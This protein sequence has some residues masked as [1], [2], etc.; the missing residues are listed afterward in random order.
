[1]AFRIDLFD[2]LFTE[3]KKLF[4][5]KIKT[6]IEVGD[7]MSEILV[8]YTR[9][10]K[11]ESMHR[12]DIVAVNT[13]GKIIDCIGDAHKKMFWRSAAKPFQALPFVAKGGVEQYGITQEELALLVS[14]HSGES[15]HVDL[16]NHILNKIALDS[17][18]LDCGTS[19]PMSSKAAKLLIENKQKPEAFHNACSGKHAGML[20]LCQMLGISIAGYT[21]PEHEVQKQ[22]HASVAQ[23]AK[24]S[25]SELEIGIDGCGVPV[26]YLPLYHMSLAYARLAK[27]E[28][29]AWG[30]DEGA[31]RKIRDAMIAYPEVLAG[32]GRIDTIVANVTKG[33]I[34]AKVGAE[35]VYCLASVP[36]G[37]GITFKIEDGSYRAI[38]PTVIG[39]LKRLE[40]ISE[41]EYHALIEKFPP[42]L[43]NHRGDIVGT[44]ET[45]F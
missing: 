34:I 31:A 29:G 18:A 45:M 21:K 3:G 23:S 1:M 20:A 24:I 10:G 25:P 40:L 33:R 27:P 15:I 37:I 8:Q 7:D 13:K 4:Y 16:V 36:D 14:S 2:S 26:F 35:A 41:T 38:H 9:A 5:N 42:I 39:I 6:I 12:G 30:C 19:R 28:E 17:S 32:T 22:M 11:V 44:I 43:K